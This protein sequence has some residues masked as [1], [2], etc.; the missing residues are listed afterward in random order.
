MNLAT[1]SRP[2]CGLHRPIPRYGAINSLVRR[3]PCAPPA[4]LARCV[5]SAILLNTLQR[6]TR[7]E[8]RTA[9]CRSHSLKPRPQSL[10]VSSDRSARDASA[11]PPRSR[12][13]RR[14][15]PP[16][17]RP[18]ATCW[19]SARSSRA[20]RGWW[21]APPAWTGWCAGCTSPSCSTSARSCA[22]A[23]W[24]CPPASPGPRSASGWPTSSR[25]LAKLG[26]AGLVVELGRRYTDSPA[27]VAAD[28]RREAR[29]AGDHAG[30][31]HPVRH[32][33]RGG[34]RPDH[35]RPAGRAAGLRRGAPDVHRTRR[36]GR[37]PGRGGAADRPHVRLPGGAGEPG[38]PGAHL[39][40]GRGGPVGAAGRLGGPL[41]LGPHRRPYLL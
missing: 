27:Q 29:P 18:S 37:L 4:H 31:G 19:G 8:A 7:K 40:P 32:H 12:P 30:P 35:R 22:A 33:H 39:L 1:K 26:A 13:G 3:I 23:S 15:T 20:A 2:G 21:P 5:G 16:S 38:T 17:T 34:A 25:D 9:E 6:T 41:P 11:G 28:G 10:T 24:C 36:R 14:C